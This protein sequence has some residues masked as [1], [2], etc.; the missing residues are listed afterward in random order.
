MAVFLSVVGSKNYSLLRNLVAP[1]LPGSKTFEQ[2]VSALKKHFEPKPL[3]IAERF[4]FHKRDQIMG[5]SISEYVAELRRFATHCEYGAHLNEALRDRLVCGIRDGHTQKKLLTIADLTLAKAMDVAQG[6]EAAERNSKALKGMEAA[7]N[8]VVTKPCYRCGGT[9]HEP[10]DCRFKNVD[11]FTCGKRGH[12]AEVCRSKK[13]PRGRQ[14]SPCPSGKQK[15]QSYGTKYVSR[16]GEPDPSELGQ[17]SDDK[18]ELEYLSLHVVRSSSTP[19]YK[20]PLIINDVAHS[21]EL[22]TGASVTLMSDTKRRELFPGTHLRESTVLLRTYSGEQLPVVG[23]MDVQVKY[24]EQQCD[25][26]LTVVSGEGPSLLG[27][28]WLQHFRLDWR[29]VRGVSSHPKGSLE[30]LLDKYGDVFTE[31]L[32]TIKSQVAKLHVKSGERPKFFKSRTVPYAM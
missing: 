31:G 16:E 9:T 26:V 20:V 19:P 21:M 18:Q 5:E 4:H 30:Y 10:K 28:N 27:R 23:E 17:I 29:E 2:L 25:L 8:I 11:C 3:V 15:K 22:D 24:G 32:G 7:V 14:S 13:M 1:S 12:I 6:E